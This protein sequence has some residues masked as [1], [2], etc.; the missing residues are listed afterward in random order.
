[1]SESSAASAKL[2]IFDFH[3][4]PAVLGKVGTVIE[5][6]ENFYTVMTE[7]KYSLLKRY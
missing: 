3:I 6:S 1:M 7:N 5:C 2:V 4:G